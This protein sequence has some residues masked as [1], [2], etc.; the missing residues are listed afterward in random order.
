MM[1]EHCNF[2]DKTPSTFRYIVENEEIKKM[3]G[4]SKSR[5]DC[6]GSLNG[7]NQ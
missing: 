5:R 7:H 4:I 6:Q 2:R 3:T 1:T